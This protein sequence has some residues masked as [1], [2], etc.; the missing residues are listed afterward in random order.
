MVYK[1]PKSM[2]NKASIIWFTGMS[3]AGKSTIANKLFEY[4][5]RNKKKVKLIDG[6]VLRNSIHQNLDFTPES[7]KKNNILTTELCLSLQND[8]DYI[9]VAVITPYRISRQRTRNRLQDR[10]T[11]IYVKTSLNELCKRDVKGLY[12][13]ALNGK[14]SNFIGIS[15]ET[16]FEE[17]ENPDIIL[18]TTIESE[19]ESFSKITDHIFWT[20]KM[21]KR[22]IITT[23]GPTSLN[24]A[25]IQK[26]EQAGVDVFRINLSH[27]KLDDFVDIVKKLKSW[28]TKPICPDT[29]GAQLRTGLLP[30]GTLR[31]AS[32]DVIEFVFMEQKINK[33]QIPLTIEPWEILEQ[34][35][36]LKIDF[37][38]VVIQITEISNQH[39]YGRVIEGGKIGTNKGISL[40]R[41]IKLPPFS[42]KDIKAFKISKE[43]KLDTFALSFASSGEDIIELRNYFDYNINIISKVESR[44]GLLNLDSICAETNAVLIDRG[45]LSR[46][47][48][49]EKI[50]F[51][52][53]YIIKHAKSKSTP[54]YVA[55]NLMENMIQ[56]SKPTRAEVHDIVETLNSGADGLVLAAE[57]AIGK[58]PV[59]CVRIM[60]R[61]MDEV[62]NNRV[63]NNNMEYM[64]SMP[65][66]RM[67]APHGGTL[68]QQN[69]KK[70]K[71]YLD[72]P[73][74]EVDD[75]IISDIVQISRGTYSPLNSFM[76]F[77][78]LTSVLDNYLLPSGISWSLPV[79]FQIRKE[80]LK[81]IPEKGEIAI[82]YQN[83]GDI[84]A[85]VK[86]EKIE[87]II[88]KEQIVKK[89]YNTSDIHHPGVKYFLENGDYLLVGKPYLIK[90]PVLSNAS[91]AELTPNQ[92]REIFNDSGWHNIV[93]F[94]TRSVV[95]LAH[96]FIQKKAL[97]IAKADAIF[98]SPVI[99]RKNVGDFKA[100]PLIKCYES[101]I[102][103]GFYH[104][105]GALLGSF[106]TYPRYCGPREALFTAICGKNFG[107][108]HVIIGKDHSG[109][110]N[111]YEPNASNKL[112]DRIDIGVNI[113]RFE[114]A[115]FC[116]EC[117]KT[118]MNCIHS[119]KDRKIL[120]AKKIKNA[121]LDDK[122]I[123]W[124]LMQS[125]N[126]K[127]LKELYLKQ[128]EKVFEK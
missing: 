4:L 9:L 118:K 40:D 84:Y 17:P 41:E 39:V 112:F 34:G 81:N 38:A 101:M 121:L 32:Y 56:N 14:I 22:K 57:T 64:F 27:T 44:I 96:E 20:K 15:P 29:E 55:T 19:D 102:K 48:P 90:N 62:E 58:Y 109:F 75:K 68:I 67:V 114:E 46:E 100:E 3:G 36:L 76:D 88:D 106:A 74:V 30:E 87:K 119:S 103:K 92:T 125:E 78:S 13:K 8:Y 7:I 99:G 1:K 113:L 6:D 23:I 25:T 12:Q 126:A 61:I 95:N 54:V 69:W 105:Y 66:D 79:I 93:G 47:V 107:C 10:Y 71:D 108:N 50:I 18:D 28:T 85:V 43:L 104:P 70:D 77:D 37:H 123:P 98:I 16:P 116:I 26:M 21:K 31:V 110:E 115:Y 33:N 51:A 128:P 49:L 86:I 122:E 59:E 5:I 82:K 124:Y 91:Y 52:Q 73:V 111:L 63:K 80:Q 35:D 45:D 2:T 127:I 117:G 94:H 97:E 60:S 83:D 53:K 72:F 42:Q 24:K 11:E 89:W 65:S 120:A